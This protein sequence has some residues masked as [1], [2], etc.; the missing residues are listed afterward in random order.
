MKKTTVTELRTVKKKSSM[1]LV[2]FN[3][4]NVNTKRANE[5]YVC[6]LNIEIYFYGVFTGPRSRDRLLRSVKKKKINK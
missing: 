2:S 1:S 4:G 5:D 6:Q 3:E